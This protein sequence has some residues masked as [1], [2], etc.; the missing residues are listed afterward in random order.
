M[1]I[2]RFRLFGS[3]NQVD[4]VI[5]ALGT[6]EQCPN[7]SRLFIEEKTLAAF[8]EDKTECYAALEEARTLMLPTSRPR[9][10]GGG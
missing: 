7:C 10:S 6:V 9:G 2:V 3:S 8:S 1:R 5:T 4:S